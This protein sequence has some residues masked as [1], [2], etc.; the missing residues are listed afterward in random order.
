MQPTIKV[1][2]FGAG[3]Q[4]GEALC[5]ELTGPGFKLLALTRQDHAGDITDHA[6]VGATVERFAPDVIIN[7][8][9]Y[10]QVDS[11]EGHKQEAFA[12]NDRA[13]ANLAR[14]AKR[15]GALLIHFGTDFVFD[16]TANRPWTENDMACPIN[17]YGLS[18]LAGESAVLESGCRHVILRVSWVHA[19]N[20]KNFVN[21]LMEWLKNQP[22]VFVV[23]DQW[24]S[25]TAA[26]DIAEA[27]KVV[28]AKTLENPS[29][30]G[31]YHFANSGYTTRFACA[32]FVASLMS[33][34]S[35]EKLKPVPSS[36]FDLPACRPLNCRLDTEKFTKTFSY[37]PRTWQEGIKETVLGQR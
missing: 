6:L 18:K 17:Q 29:L 36:R 34:H 32:R 22:E 4:V 15:C 21:S 10:T 31:I 1:L 19:P 12:I 7:A 20:H 33:N 9:A 24:G 13:V 2:I 23:D 35:M 26:V 14:C 30:D 37:E 28:I 3:G 25:P 11:A 5:R 16:G 27:V 8:A